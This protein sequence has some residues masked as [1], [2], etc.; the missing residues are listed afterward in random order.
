MLTAFLRGGPHADQDRL[1]LALVLVALDQRVDAGL[2]DR[3]PPIK[4]LQLAVH[5][6]GGDWWRN[7]EVGIVI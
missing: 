5:A 1:E 3:P 4:D 7:D 6:E 2:S